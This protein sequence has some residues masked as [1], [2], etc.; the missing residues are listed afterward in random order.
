MV[1]VVVTIVQLA[2]YGAGADAW[3]TSKDIAS[4]HLFSVVA[5]NNPVL[6]SA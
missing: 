5:E 6:P 4:S 2:S 3:V 1:L